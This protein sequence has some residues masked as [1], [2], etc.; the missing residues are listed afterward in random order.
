MQDDGF[1]SHK[2]HYTQLEIY[3]L[4]LFPNELWEVIV[5]NISDAFKI[6]MISK[7]EKR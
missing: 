6:F 1:D 3:E 7:I 2:T 5:C 4:D